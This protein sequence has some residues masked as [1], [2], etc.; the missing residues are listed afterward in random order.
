MVCYT[1]RIRLVQSD[2][3]N[4]NYLMSVVIL[5]AGIYLFAVLFIGEY[6]A[7]GLVPVNNNPA[8][9]VCRVEVIVQGADEDLLYTA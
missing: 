2:F 4:K 8:L 3:H 5:A 9:S 1:T 6:R 7:P